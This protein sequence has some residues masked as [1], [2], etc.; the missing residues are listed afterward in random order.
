MGRTDDKNCWV[1]MLPPLTRDHYLNR[2]GSVLRLLFL[3][4]STL[5]PNL[6]C[7]VRTAFLPLYLS[8]H[9]PTIPG[10]SSTLRSPHQPP[11]RILNLTL[12]SKAMPLRMQARS[13]LT[14]Q[15][16]LL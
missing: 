15:R 10:P 6:A 11:R 12:P 8:Y 16:K 14:I 5:S 1:S 3:L 4:I 7:Y 9:P 13:V 2:D